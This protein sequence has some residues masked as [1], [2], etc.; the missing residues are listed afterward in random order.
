MSLVTQ[1]ERQQR[2]KEARVQTALGHS[3]SARSFVR[4]CSNCPQQPSRPQVEVSDH[5]DM[6]WGEGGISI[7][8]LFPAEL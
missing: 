7:P 6:G 2:Q 3:S 1:A 8:R 4:G 5:A